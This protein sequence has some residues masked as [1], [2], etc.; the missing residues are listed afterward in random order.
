M[1]K[2]TLFWALAFCCCDCVNLSSFCRSHDV[3]TCDP[4][5]VGQ[6]AGR[7]PATLG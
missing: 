3:K 2:V 6:I 1:E 5:R 7:E 4:Q